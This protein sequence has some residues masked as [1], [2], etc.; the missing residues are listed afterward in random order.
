[1]CWRSFAS[2]LRVHAAGGWCVFCGGGV[3]TPSFFSCQPATHRVSGVLGS[4]LLGVARRPTRGDCTAVVVSPTQQPYRCRLGVCR[5]TVDWACVGTRRFSRFAFDLSAVEISYLVLFPWHATLRQISGGLWR[6]IAR[7]RRCLRS[8]LIP[9]TTLILRIVA[10]G[11]SVFVSR[12]GWF[13]RHTRIHL[14]AGNRLLFCETQRHRCGLTGVLCLD[15]CLRPL[16]S[17]ALRVRA[18]GTSAAWR[19]GGL[20]GRC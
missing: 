8:R 17:L 5:H 2:A 4:T 14:H 9:D 1:M 11:F 10:M 3:E 15:R 6:W 13:P 12:F 19:P 20:R 7:L 16:L 18:P